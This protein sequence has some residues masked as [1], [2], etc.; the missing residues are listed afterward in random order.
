[1]AENPNQPREDDVVLADQNQF[2]CLHT[3]TGHSAR[4]FSVAISPDGQTFASG[5]EDGEI[6]LWNLDTGELIRSLDRHE[7]I[8]Q[9]HPH[10]GERLNVLEEW[11]DSSLV[12]SITFSPDSQI[13]VI[14]SA[15]G[16][17]KLWNLE[18]G[19]LLRSLEGHSENVNS[20][21]ISSDGQILVSGSGNGEIKLWNLRTGELLR[22][23]DGNSD[24]VECLAI[25]PDGQILCH[26]SRWS[27]P[28]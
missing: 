22:T 4:V 15:H 19:E 23:F 27:A 13:L 7:T 16:K 12:F 17:I 21:T 6:R 2:Q 5:G 3:L 26:Q 14:G 24:W 8:K 25:S 10:T 28:R 18:T 1:M 11:K 9:W 20:I